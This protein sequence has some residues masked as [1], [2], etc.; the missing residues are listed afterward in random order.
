MVPDVGE[1]P[2]LG[3]FYVKSVGSKGLNDKTIQGVPKK[4][5]IRN[6]YSDLFNSQF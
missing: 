5:S 2:W 4:I 6:F 1:I 3:T